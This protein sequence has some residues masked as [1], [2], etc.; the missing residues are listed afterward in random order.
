MTRQLDRFYAKHPRAALAIAI[1]IA[2]V[3]L[4]AI[5][6]FDRAGQQPAQQIQANTRNMT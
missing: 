3:C 4:V 6:S 1:V 5:Q 2:F